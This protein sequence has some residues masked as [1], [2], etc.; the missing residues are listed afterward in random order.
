LAADGAH[1]DRLMFCPHIPDTPCECRK[2]G[3]LNYNLA[4]AELHLDPSRSL[5]VGDRISDVL[6]ALAFGGMGVLVPHSHTK[7]EDVA[8]AERE[9]STALTLGDAV[10][11]FLA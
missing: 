4:S 8:R 9:L 2:P 7:P 1:F 6:P 5:F 3:L 10:D 11:R